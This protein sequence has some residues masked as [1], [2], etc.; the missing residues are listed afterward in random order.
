MYCPQDSNVFAG[1]ARPNKKAVSTTGEPVR[2]KQ[3]S[4]VFKIIIM[5]NIHIAVF[6]TTPL[7]LLVV[8]KKTGVCRLCGRSLNF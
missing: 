1:V 6:F 8:I 3:T 2:M 4:P 7:F 5:L